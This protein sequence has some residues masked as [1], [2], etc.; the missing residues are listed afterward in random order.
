MGS[1]K[2]L[3][4][5]RSMIDLIERNSLFIF[6]LILAS[7]SS[8]VSQINNNPSCLCDLMSSRTGSKKN[9]VLPY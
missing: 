8:L 2:Q 9:I 1:V 5:Y 4:N 7:F 6:T 3:I